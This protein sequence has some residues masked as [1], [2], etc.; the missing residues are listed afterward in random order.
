MRVFLQRRKAEGRDAKGCVVACCTMRWMGLSLSEE[1]AKVVA[2][3]LG[4]Q[5]GPLGGAVGEK[6][7]DAKEDASHRTV[8]LRPVEGVR[9]EQGECAG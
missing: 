6:G 7:A 4:V 9:A 3:G 1:V 5:N 8:S 2:V